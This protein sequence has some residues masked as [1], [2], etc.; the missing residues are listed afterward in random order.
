MHSPDVIRE[1]HAWLR[2]S[3]ARALA[4]ARTYSAEELHRQFPIGIGSVF[5]TLLHLLGAEMIW[6]GVIQGT[7][8]RVVWPTKASHPTLDAIEA[9]W[10][11][12]RRDWDRA[13][14]ALTPAECERV[15]ERVRDGKTYLQRV[16]DACMQVP[17]HANYHAAQL[18]F[19]HRSLRGPGPNP[20]S[21]SSWIVWAREQM[22]AR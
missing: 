5:E 21:D 8:D 10:Q 1:A 7:A 2:W 22:A 6:I 12:T 14:A 13:L 9:A 16:A 15:V 17:T 20:Y 11:A 19:M 18:S 3:T 4:A